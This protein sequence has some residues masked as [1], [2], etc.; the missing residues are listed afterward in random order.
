MKSNLCPNCGNPLA[1]GALES[2]CPACLAR[3]S[4]RLE[5]EDS[6]YAADHQSPVTGDKSPTARP[7]SC[8]RFGD[9]D[10]LEEIGRGGMGVVYRARQRGLN[11]VVALK[12]IPFGPLAT[13]DSVRRFHAEAE[14]AAQLQ[15]PNIVAIHEVGEQSGQHYFSMDYIQGRTLAEVLREGPLPARRA[16]EYLRTVAQAVHYAHER[17]ILHRDLK[18]S[19]ILIDD[20]DQPRIADFGLAKRLSGDSS[21]TLTGQ[22]LGS[23]NYIPPEQASAKRQPLTPRSDVYSLGAVLYHTLTG[24]PPFQGES[25]ESVLGQLA[26]QEPVPLRLLNANLPR[27]LETICLKCLMKEPPRRYDTAREL[28]DELGRFLRGEPV[29]AKPAS[30]AEKVWRWCRR[31]PAL[32][33]TLALL[34]VVFLV[35]AVG[36][37]WQWRRAEATAAVLRKQVYAADMEAAFR[38]FHSGGLDQAQRLLSK[39]SPSA[40]AAA[41]LRQWEWRYLWQECLS[42]EGSIVEKLPGSVRALEFSPDSR[43]LAAGTEEGAFR[44]WDTASRRAVFATN[45]AGHRIDH[46][47]FSPDGARL[48]ILTP[49]DATYLWDTKKPFVRRILGGGA[50]AAAFAP[51]GNILALTGGSTLEVI[52]LEPE[53]KIRDPKQRIGRIDET[54]GRWATRLAFS[55]DNRTLAIGCDSGLCYLWDWRAQRELE[56]WTAHATPPAKR[57]SSPLAVTFSPDGTV[58][59]TAGLDMDVRLWSVPGHQLL[60]VLAKAQGQVSSPRFVQDGSA[61][62]TCSSDLHL[63][64]WETGTGRLLEAVALPAENAFRLR[65]AP[66]GHGVAIGGQDGSVQLWRAQ[67]N[68]AVHSA[69]ALSMT[70]EGAIRSALGIPNANFV[71]LPIDAGA[72]VLD[73]E[74]GLLLLAPY[75]Y[76]WRLWDVRSP[77]EVQ[78]GVVAPSVISF[79]PLHQLLPDLKF[80]AYTTNKTLALWDVVSGQIETFGSADF[81][82]SAAMEVSSNGCLLAA[83]GPARVVVWDLTTRRQ[84][85][86]W[87]FKNE[88]GER[89]LRLARDGA[90]IVTTGHSGRAHLLDVRSG[91]AHEL[92]A[93]ARVPSAMA[94]ARNGQRLV[95]VS[96]VSTLTVYDLG[97]K[98]EMASWDNGLELAVTSVAFSPTA[99][100]LAVGTAAG[101]IQLWDLETQREVA[102]INGHPGPIHGLG[103]LDEDTLVSLGQEG[104]RYWRAPTLQTSDSD[105]TGSGGGNALGLRTNP[106]LKGRLHATGPQAGL[107]IVPAI[108]A[109][110]ELSWNSE[111]NRSYQV[112]YCTSPNTNDWF[113]LGSPLQGNGGTNFVFASIRERT[114]RLY[115]VLQDQNLVVNGDFS[116]GDTGFSNDYFFVQSGRDIAASTYGA[117]A[118]SQDFNPDYACFADHTSGTGIMLLV[119]GSPFPNQVVWTETISTTTNTPYTFSAWATAAD[120]LSPAVL[121]FLINGVQ[122]GGDLVLSTN[123]G[124]WQQFTATWYSGA[125]TSAILSI[126]DTNV[127]GPG[128][129]FAL[130]DVSFAVAAAGDSVDPAANLGRPDRAE[131]LE[132]VVPTVAAAVEFGWKSQTNVIYQAQYSTL[133]K[134]NEW[135]DLGSL[136]Q[137]NGSTNY[138]F[139]C[140]G[141]EP[142]KSYRVL[143]SP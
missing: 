89:D 57:E 110:V 12:M 135:F 109:A 112:Q 80:I 75:G 62:L 85:R 83:G 107:T 56:S 59:A 118:N 1:A 16:A 76:L 60:R 132:Y 131:P 2:L 54:L 14:A 93:P 45:L 61:L 102:R 87:E 64:L 66:D 137:G 133:L 92:L 136:I 122:A 19:N 32:A 70:K 126:V 42:A 11:R 95:V 108:V 128:N 97:R 116:G 78:R 7:R 81:G 125:S 129:D 94:L 100:R 36:V 111:L 43:R 29:L 9:Y 84:L 58:L 142:K 30:R 25:I 124:H 44:I 22:L 4:F 41:G 88:T 96:G 72:S 86:S 38:A 8:A 31:K 53:E 37:L 68:V 113:N 67:T 48:V 79:V 103:F 106:E 10:L 82:D 143:I 33:A 71:A 74:N 117:R 101:R 40:G 17:G 52:R 138:F 114:N 55:P 15:H 104:L 39:Y 134:A 119:D 90:F 141:D 63:R 139:D 26:T 69:S 99:T 47:V 46:V 120:A 115:R 73:E 28:A 50:V 121:Q 35:G 140:A 98:E 23:P 13:E 77:H 123:A 27:D 18:P 20:Q 5:P 91:E 65:L 21:I 34:H 105:W 24:R 3:L 130:D 49:T 127:S 6:A 51:D